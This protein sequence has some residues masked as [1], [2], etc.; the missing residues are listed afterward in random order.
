MDVYKMIRDTW[1]SLLEGSLYYLLIFTN[2]FPTTYLSSFWLN[3]LLILVPESR[4]W[5]STGLRELE[6][7]GK[8]VDLLPH[9]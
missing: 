4:I 6:R 3:L 7:H 5:Q 8:E 9:V 2:T 1:G